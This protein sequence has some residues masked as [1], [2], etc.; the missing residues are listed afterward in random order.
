MSLSVVD[1]KGTP[2]YFGTVDKIPEDVKIVVDFRLTAEKEPQLREEHIRHACFDAYETH[3]PET[4]KDLINDLMAKL[5]EGKSLYLLDNCGAGNSAMV[6]WILTVKV[7]YIGRETGLDMV[8]SAY[9]SQN[10]LE[11]KWK[12]LGVPRYYRL[13]YYGELFLR[14]CKR[15]DFTCR[16]V[17]PKPQKSCVKGRIITENLPHHE[18]NGPITEPI[19]K[20]FL[21]IQITN[22]NNCE[23]KGL[24][25]DIIGPYNFP[26]TTVKKETI[27]AA[28]LTNLIYAV[29]VYQSVIDE[30]DNLRTLFYEDCEGISKKLPNNEKRRRAIKIKHPRAKEVTLEKHY[31]T[32]PKGEPPVCYLWLNKFLLEIEFRQIWSRIYVELLTKNQFYKN[33]QQ[34]Q[35]NGIS[36]LLMD[37]DGYNFIEQ[38]LTLQELFED[39]ER[40]WSFTHVL[41]GMLTDQ[42]V[43]EKSNPISS[44][45]DVESGDS[46]SSGEKK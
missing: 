19:I 23:W 35:K 5:A 6:A 45:S 1:I 16:F 18:S 32:Y 36:L 29:S 17:K 7:L 13:W 3:R 44:D 4:F 30:D 38:G 14:G 20:D 11:L 2:L 42:R 41:Y 9:L 40:P 12:E 22:K 21:S 28:N 10:D 26:I 25:P 33:L 27:C 15:K 24:H 37:Y 39:P 46:D 8:K 31:P 43:W 34:L